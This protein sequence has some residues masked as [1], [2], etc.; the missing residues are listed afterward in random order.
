MKKAGI[1]GGTFSPPHYGHI[2]AARSFAREL[3]LD[4]LIIMP[5]NIPPHKQITDIT[6]HARLEMA[7]LAFDGM[8]NTE[9]SDYEINTPGKSYTANTLTHLRSDDT[10]LYFLCGTDMFTTL[11]HWYRPDIICSLATIVLAKRDT[12][13]DEDIERANETLK[14]KFGASTIVLTHTPRILSSS[15]VR[16]K[17]A[18]G[19]DVSALIPPSVLRYINQNGLYKKI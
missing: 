8:E 19:E 18:K 3:S 2:A 13:N 7:R 11:E 12:D 15:L 16:E 17:I 5:A 4:R 14:S 10:E 9:V 6:P 1:F